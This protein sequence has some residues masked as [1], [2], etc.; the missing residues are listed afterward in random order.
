MEPVTN[1]ITLLTWLRIW[2]CRRCLQCSLLYV[3]G[4]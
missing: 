1:L 4:L 2:V 3:N